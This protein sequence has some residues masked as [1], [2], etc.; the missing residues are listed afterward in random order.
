MK[1][2]VIILAFLEQKS[3]EHEEEPNDEDDEPPV[4]MVTRPKDDREDFIIPVENIVHEEV[5]D[6][7]IQNNIVNNKK[8]NKSQ[9]KDK[10]KK[11][12]STSNLVFII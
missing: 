11:T 10:E 2:Y 5:H 1:L 7:A 12:K 6:Q 8:D 3:I 4:A 9:I